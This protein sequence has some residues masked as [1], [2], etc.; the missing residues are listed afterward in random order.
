MTTKSDINISPL[1]LF[2]GSAAQ[3]P[4]NVLAL[5]LMMRFKALWQLVVGPILRHAFKVHGTAFQSL[6]IPP[7]RLAEQKDS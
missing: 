3:P 4:Q 5:Y 7:Q 2:R 1:G 6:H